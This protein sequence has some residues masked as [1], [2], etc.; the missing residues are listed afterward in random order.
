ML[1]N[2]ETLIAKFQRK[3]KCYNENKPPAL[4]M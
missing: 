4:L 3:Q 2:R 1:D